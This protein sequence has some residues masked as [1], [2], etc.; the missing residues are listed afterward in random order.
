MPDHF[1]PL[2]RDTLLLLPPSL[3][4]WLPEDH[5]A[6]F[7]A[8][9]VT[10]LDVRP[11]RARYAGRGTA[12]Y[13]P[14]MMVGLLL[15]G[16]ATGV[17]S[18]R[19]LERATYDS[20]AFRYLSADQHPEH[21]TISDF[22]KRFLP[23]LKE[24]FEQILLIAAES[25]LLKV[26]R[27]SLDGT[28][29]KANASKHHALSHE[30]AKKLKIR[31]K[32]E[33]AQLMRLAAKA[34][35]DDLPDG[36]DIPKELARR[37]ARLARIDEAQAA[38]RAREQ[39]RIGT[40]QS[41]HRAKMAT[42]R[43]RERKRG[44]AFRRPAPKAPSR[45]IRPQAQVNLTDDESR[46]M[47]SSEGFVQ[48]YNAQA[49][50]DTESRLIVGSF[51]SQ[52]PTDRTLLEPMIEALGALPLQTG[53]VS[54]VL[55]DAGYFS[56]ANV[57]RCVATGLTPYIATGRDKHYEGLSRFAEPPDL[58]PDADAVDQMQH[59]LKTQAGRKVYG[60]RK[61][62]VEPTFGIIKSVLGFRQFLLRGHDKVDAEWRLVCMGF[63]VKRMHTLSAQK[64][65]KWVKTG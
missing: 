18:S 23:E 42:R 46:I 45:Q 62:T 29:I 43:E 25:G 64:N 49:G 12:A 60:Q 4:D 58:L 65:V 7:V 61:S 32:R 57:T 24:L 55:A 34:D 20:V 38:I 40:E 1:K 22:R 8:D 53:L 19:K 26:G 15:Y 35:K 54:E 14:E 11:I 48:A 21:D 50:V 10:K 17:F 47:P 13:Q 9:V 39:E 37:E 51:V 44:K 59:R 6:R 5:L 56:A 3:N 63:N 36:L 31:L 27:V 52:A 30:Y 16:Y 41:A 33:V 2:D 28:K